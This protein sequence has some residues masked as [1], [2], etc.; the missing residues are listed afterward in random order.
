MIVA[1][2]PG[3]GTDIVGRMLAQKL[4]E[5][6]GQSVLVE[7][8][9]GASGHNGTELAA[10]AAPHGHTILMGNVAPNAINVKLF[11]NPPFD[12]VPDFVP[13]SLVAPTPHIPLGHPPPPAR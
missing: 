1:Y 2:P 7:N 13:V 5:T 8:R 11:K 4:G 10:R 12:P 6:L 3:G 9:G